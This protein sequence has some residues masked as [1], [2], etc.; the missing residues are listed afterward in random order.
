MGR[1][2]RRPTAFTV[3]ELLIRNPQQAALPALGRV[4]IKDMIGS[5]Y[6]NSY[7]CCF[8]FFLSR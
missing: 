3:P 1:L 7:F 2:A 6:R 4:A 5:S 8:F